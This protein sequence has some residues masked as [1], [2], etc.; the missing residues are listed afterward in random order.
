MN[1]LEVIQ[2]TALTAI[3]V[4]A[5]LT[6]L[7]LARDYR[8]KLHRIYLGWGIAAILWNLGVYHL[9]KDITPNEAFL[10]AKLLQLGIIFI[11]VIM[12][13]LCVVIAQVK[14]GWVMPG[15]YLL[16]AGFAV[17]LYFN[18]FIIGVRH[19]EVGY[20]SVPGPY[21]V[22]FSFVYTA[23]GVFLLVFLYRRQQTAR[24]M[25]RK[26]L[27][28]MLAAV[29]GLAIF[30][31]NDLMP[32]LGRETYPIIHVKFFPLGSLAAVFYVL[33]I[34]YSVLQHRLLDIHVALSRMAAQMVRLTFMMLVGFL[35][36]LVVSEFAPNIFT[37]ISFAGALAVLLA[38]ALVA[39]FFFPLFFG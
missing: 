7:V 35:L 26:R 16:H 2:I 33:I 6:L 20:W 18:K 8:S 15:L 38:S 25:Q 1:R 11:P 39:S 12:V 29:I 32:I 14:T 30:G 31:T 17:S 10:W 23:I 19:L 22:A 36:L 37:P 28:A 21:F 9:S 34:G 13:H 5:A 24:P 4:N 27:R 3:T